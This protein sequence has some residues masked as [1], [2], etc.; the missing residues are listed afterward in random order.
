MSLLFVNE[1]ENDD[2]L[3]NQ[4][5]N[6]D[7]DRGGSLFVEQDEEHESHSSNI[8]TIAPESNEIPDDA[9][10]QDDASE[11]VSDH[12][13]S[14]SLPLK[15]QQ[16]IFENMLTK[17][18][19]LI[20]G[21]G[22]GWQPLTSNLLHAL[23]TPT[24]K[25]SK[26]RPLI[27]LLNARDEENAKISEELNE[28]NWIDIED[29]GSHCPFIILNNESTTADKRSKLYSQGGIISITGRILV[30]DFLS[31]V[32]QPNDVTGLFILHA[33]TVDE[34]SKTSFI[35]NLYRDGGND[36]GFVKAVT[37]E[38]ESFY[39]FS[40]LQLK[41]RALALSNV[42]LWPRY[43]VDVMK[44]LSFGEQNLLTRERREQ[45]KRKNAIEIKIKL[46]PMMFKIQNAIVS[47]F[48]ECLSELKRHNAQAAT[49]YWD[50]ENM[51]DIQFIRRIEGTLRP[52]WHR[53]SWTSKKLLEDLKTLNSLM[54]GLISLDSLTF[55]ELVQAIYM[56]SFKPNS[57]GV[58]M[59]PWL[60]VDDA[61]TV[62]SY[63]KERALGKV[64]KRNDVIENE[65]MYTLE[66]HPK[67]DQ[68]GIL[69]DD[70]IYEKQYKDNDVEG[71]IL[72]MCSQL[73]TI[74]QLKSVLA[75][76]KK[77][78]NTMTGKKRFSARK[79][80]VKELNNYTKWKD[81][82]SLTKKISSKMEEDSKPQSATGQLSNSTEQD[83]ENLNI[84]KTFTRG[85]G[86]PLSKRRRT[87]GAAAVA[88]VNRLYYASEA[89]SE[90]VE[91]D[92]A[93]LLN[94]K[95]EVVSDGIAEED[96]GIEIVDSENENDIE[97]IEEQEAGNGG[98][99]H[100]T[101]ENFQFT[102]INLSDQI[103]FEVYDEKTNDSL[104]LELSPSYIIMYE[105]NVSFVR[106][107]EIYQ[108]I[109]KNTPARPY[110]MYYDG[111][112]EEQK[113]Y[114]SLKRE[115][116]AFNKIIRERANLSKHFAQSLENNKFHITKKDVINT[117]IAGGSNFR[118]GEDEFKVVVDVREFNA[119]LPN[120]LYRAG[121]KLVPCMLTV[122][123]YILTPKICIERKSI[124]DL[125]S[126]FNSGRLV[127]QCE[128]MFRNYELPTLLI[129]FSEDNSFSLEPFGYS[130]KT[131]PNAKNDN[132]NETGE[133][134]KLKQEAIQEKIVT[135]L[136]KFPKLKIIWSS[137]PYETAQIFLTLKREQEEPDVAAAITK[138][139]MYGDT[140]NP[141]MYNDDAIDLIKNIPGINNN[142][143]FQIITRIRSIEDLV[144]VSADKLKELLG[145]EN[146]RKAFDFIH[147]SSN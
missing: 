102:N 83:D 141:P 129:E 37:D 103:V 60:N 92:P 27:F 124:S 50:V 147:R 115:K 17:D 88:N 24:L 41:L 56:Q 12:V 21:R 113:Y 32:I 76:M 42:F 39:G 144:S 30:V 69:L 89:N 145:D 7:G 9:V 11:E 54:E 74:H 131:N 70:I 95:R 128:Q 118:S 84:S 47:C 143:Y 59:L 126:S 57:R 111:S 146:G 101:P 29:N 99:F 19:L 33:E 18:G 136:I 63:A 2:D 44:T 58:S 5:S 104:L 22:L 4:L 119:T 120:L 10:E 48:K 109:H 80:M 90:A 43:R 46:T 71:P 75:N 127:D 3:Q 51:H 135:L 8:E 138:G 13:V 68:L 6:I 36:W 45:D 137:S 125:V 93:I 107:V 26:K 106:K 139:V 15:Y 66:E 1:D 16:T 110:L 38:P 20:L 134:V 52:D 67:W 34:K 35:V 72:I 122:G 140:D 132:K 65:E 49:E 73:S 55:Y 117:R 79:Y 121:F 62:I 61:S 53:V 40:P 98:F 114:I 142:N 81:I 28:L 100:A 78:E 25:T 91:L 23:S 97:I 96:D 123:D 77:E 14:C 112:I 130:K 87:R 105:P 108:A 82:T 31:G 116:E 64:V 133:P 86:H 94:L 85:K